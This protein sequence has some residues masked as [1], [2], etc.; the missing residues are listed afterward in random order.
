[1]YKKWRKN[2]QDILEKFSHTAIPASGIKATNRT[3]S[4]SFPPHLPVP[5]YAELPARL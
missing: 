4:P 3:S 1:M 2:S 5:H